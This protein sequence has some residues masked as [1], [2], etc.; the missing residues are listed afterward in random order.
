MTS[1]GS[2]AE[3]ILDRIVA[4]TRRRL[5]AFPFDR[6]AL[7]RAAADAPPPPDALASLR[8][9][10]VRVI[11]EVKRRSPS[12][13]AIRTDADP[14]AVARAYATHGAA[15]IS[16]LTEPEY[17]GGSLEDLVEV[18]GAVPL[19]CLRKDFVVDEVQLLEARAAGAAMALLIVAALDDTTLARLHEAGQRAGLTM[20]VEAHDEDEVRRAVDIGARLIGVNN[21]DLR[22]FHIDLATSERL[23]PLIPPHAVAVTESGVATAADVRR[24]RAAGYDVFLVGSSLMAAGDP[25][26][27][28]GA[29]LAAD[30]PE[31]VR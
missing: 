25:G 29:L 4:R 11:A 1:A 10:G 5:A 12:A 13:G 14:V 6:G 21:R 19:P 24:L 20:L 15:A 23:R 7:E 17:F 30:T 18:A 16:V 9:P 26:A 2:A 22:S 3:T 28:L 31:P 27:A 8:A